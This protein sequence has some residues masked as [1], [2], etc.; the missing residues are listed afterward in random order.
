M[1]E[2]PL[3]SV[4][5]HADA[6]SSRLSRRT[7]VSKLLLCVGGALLML[8]V[9]EVGAR[10]AVF[11]RY[12]NQ[13]EG[14]HHIFKYEP[15]L[16]VR[17]NDR[18]LLRYP[19]RRADELRVLILGGSTADSLV[20]VG[21]EAYSQLFGD[22]SGRRTQV[23][24]FAQG[25]AI[26]SQQVI[27]L[28]RYGVRLHPDIVIAVDGANDIVAMTKGAPPG[29]PYTDGYVEMAVHHPFMN[30]AFAI[31]RYS[32]FLNVF[33]KIRERRDESARQSDGRAV[34]SMVSEYL[35]NQAAMHAIASGIGAQFVTVLQPYLHLRRVNTPNELKLRAQTNYAYRKVFM[36]TVLA[37][38]RTELAQQTEGTNRIFLDGSRAFDGST[39]DCFID[40]VHLTGQGKRLLVGYIAE[41]LRDT[42]IDRARTPSS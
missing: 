9:L 35:A 36:A 15:F 34:D 33:R 18:F 14:F 25:G 17:T 28:A 6:G 8:G 19:E 42:L 10:L 40:E 13:N 12:G 20:D 2:V 27:M 24:N 31:G 21:Y 29:I 16:G 23:I 30:A 22:V 5:R 1:V 26:S 41:H 39:E 11:L 37:R 32:Q 38:L 3:D 4:A 7:A